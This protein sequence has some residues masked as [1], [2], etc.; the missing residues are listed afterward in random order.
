MMA[1]SSPISPLSLTFTYPCLRLRDDL[2]NAYVSKGPDAPEHERFFHKHSILSLFT[3][4]RIREVLECLCSNCQDQKQLI[5]KRDSG[6]TLAAITGRA[7]NSQNNRSG[8]IILFALLV[9]IECP[10]LINSFL[11]K[12]LSDQKLESK[13]LEFTADHVQQNYWPNLARRLADRFYWN[14][15]KFF[16]PVMKEEVYVEYPSNTILPLVNEVPLG[17]S[18]AHGEIVSE[19]SYGDVFA[20]DIVDEYKQFPVGG[21]CLVKFQLS[22]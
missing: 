6:D 9:F 22:S 21:P 4:A 11:D 12:S 14:K 15:Y 1:R 20:F 16:V 3:E 10:V 7:S 5:G 2:D 19:G 17:R 13:L 18:T 8:T